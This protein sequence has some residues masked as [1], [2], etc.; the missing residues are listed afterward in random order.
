[1]FTAH[2]CSWCKANISS[3]AMIIRLSFSGV[4]IQWFKKISRMC[5]V[6]DVYNSCR[7]RTRQTGDTQ[8]SVGGDFKFRKSIC[9][10]KKP[11]YY[12]TTHSSKLNTFPPLNTADFTSKVL[13][14]IFGNLLGTFPSG[15][16]PILLFLK[17]NFCVFV[18][19]LLGEFAFI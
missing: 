6:T 19:P 17:S 16:K 10:H 15:L 13:I 8:Q 9:V 12:N 2:I 1:M 7:P 5:S 18:S 14:L 3:C 4:I 11:V